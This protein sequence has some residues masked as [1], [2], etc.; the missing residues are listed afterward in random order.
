MGHAVDEDAARLE[1]VRQSDA[2]V[3]VARPDVAAETVVALVG[4]ADRRLVTGNARD[5]GDRRER[6]LVEHGHARLAAGEDRGTQVEAGPAGPVAAEPQAGAAS[7]RLADLAFRRLA[8]VG[9]RQR[10]HVG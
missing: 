1:A 10:S 2:P 3:E 7:H 5:S 6:L 4:E 8:E 9:A